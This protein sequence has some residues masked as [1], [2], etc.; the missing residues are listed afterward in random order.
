M[1]IHPIQLC[2]R[3]D[4]VTSQSASCDG[5]HNCMW[6]LWWRYVFSPLSV[7]KLWWYSYHSVMHHSPCVGC[8]PLCV[9]SVIIFSSHLSVCWLWWYL[10]HTVL[11][12]TVFVNCDIFE[13]LCIQCICEGCY[14]I[15]HLWR[16]GIGLNLYV[17]TCVR[18]CDIL[19]LTLTG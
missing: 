2:L 14:D 6:V 5:I 18:F 19:T 16:S 8:A 17:Y 11:H 3:D 12:H 4:I 10:H 7:H 13:P 9:F 15:V 1:V